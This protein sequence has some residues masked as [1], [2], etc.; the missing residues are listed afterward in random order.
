[1]VCLLFFISFD[2]FQEEV[3]FGK[4]LFCAPPSWTRAPGR[5][6]AIRGTSDRYLSVYRPLLM[7]FSLRLSDLELNSSTSSNLLSSY[8]TAITMRSHCTPLQPLEFKA[9]LCVHQ[10]NLRIWI[11]LRIVR[12]VLVC[13]GGAIPD[14]A[15]SSRVSVS[16]FQTAHSLWCPFGRLAFD[17]ESRLLISVR[18]RFSR[19]S[20]A[21]RLVWMASNCLSIQRSNA[22]QSDLDSSI[23]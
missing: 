14:S 11:S 13:A 1:M 6:F 5:S 12:T 9:V 3:N 15:H 7:S 22:V 21:S 18:R 10:T 20:P 16:M 4:Q 2:Y 23:H 17:C 19:W 8:Q